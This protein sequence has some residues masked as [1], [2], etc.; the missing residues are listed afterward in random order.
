MRGNVKTLVS[1]VLLLYKSLKIIAY[2]TSLFC[3]T[4]NIRICT[5]QGSQVKV[6]SLLYLIDHYTSTSE[7]VVVYLHSFCISAL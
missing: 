6:T 4:M 1:A 3:S 7:R 2:V 5:Q